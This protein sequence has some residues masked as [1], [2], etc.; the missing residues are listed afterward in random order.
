MKLNVTELKMSKIKGKINRQSSNYT[1]NYTP[2][3]RFL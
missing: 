1:P 3:P 2:S